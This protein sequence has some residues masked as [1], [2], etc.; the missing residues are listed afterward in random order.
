MKPAFSPDDNIVIISGIAIVL[1]SSN[2]KGLICSI[3]IVL[4]LVV[5]LLLLLIVWI[6]V[7]GIVVVWIVVIG[8][9]AHL[10][11]F[12]CLF[13]DDLCINV[14]LHVLQINVLIVF[15]STKKLVIASVVFLQCITFWKWIFNLL[16]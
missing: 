14:N 6:I 7:V 11:I 4:L 1:T 12:K 9:W 10:E 16:G 5:L 13:N 15:E 3:F 2:P 8:V